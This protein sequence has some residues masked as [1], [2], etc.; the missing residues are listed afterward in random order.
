MRGPRR[1]LVLSTAALAVAGTLAAQP[2]SAS[3]DPGEDR[4][5]RASTGASGDLTPVGP[6]LRDG[7]LA[8]DRGSL[9]AAK[10]RLAARSDAPGAEPVAS[11][12][13]DVKT[14]PALDFTTSD[15][16]VKDY[17]LRGIGDHIQVWVAEDREF[18]DGDCRNALGLTEIT[19]AQVT[20]FVTEFDT[21]I[22]PEESAAFSVPPE[23]TGSSAGL[24]EQLDLPADY[25][26]VPAVESDDTVVLVD[27]VRDDNFHEPTSTDGQTFTAGFFSPDFNQ[28]VDRNVMTI[29]AFDWLHRTGA[30]PPDDRSDPEYAACA[31]ANDVADDRAYGTPRP[32]SY[33][34]TFAHEYQHLLESYAD[35]DEVTWVDEGLADYAQTL[36][37]YVDPSLAADDPA[38]DSHIASFLG[39]GG[40]HFGGPENSLTLWG[41]QGA[42]EILADY[43]AA[44]TMMEYLRDKYGADILTDLHRAPGNGLT[45]LDDVL[46]ARGA[47]RSARRTLHDWA[48]AM[49]LDTATSSDPRWAPDGPLSVETLRATV[50][51]RSKQA[52][53]SPG[54]PPNGSDYV[55]FRDEDGRYLRAKAL[56]SLSFRGARTLAPTPV[57]WSSVAA[58][59]DATTPDSTCDA[60]PAETG[61]QALYSGC[62]RNLDRSIARAV[63]VPDGAARLTFDALWDAEAGWDF[64]FVQVS[65]DGGSSWTSLG[66]T[67]TT[68]EHDPDAVPE[69]VDKLPGFTGDSGSWKSQAVDLSAYAGQQVLLGFRY[70]TD[71]NVDEAGIWLRNIA[72]GGVAV[73]TDPAG[74]QSYTQVKPVAVSGFT[75]RLVGLSASGVRAHSRTLRLDRGF[76][77]ALRRQALR[78]AVGKRSRLVGAIVTYDE[79]T[80]TLTPY[81]R[82]RLTVN[83]HPQPGG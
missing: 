35:P 69:V 31:A 4:P 60:V 5:P 82:Y 83:G 52:F 79:P 9:A 30:T 22:H 37:G 48:A 1:S 45:G 17:T 38:A 42:P 18:P 12:V 71:P 66:A 80:E 29:D 64:A 7:K 47:T 78:Q 59:P 6:D 65:T 70:V 20:G 67:D 51:W 43:G 50:N 39:F 21:N 53:G 36:V 19:D 25:Y 68:T 28:L 16:Y 15:A 13:G 3:A 44:Y 2:G 77:V 57:E 49:A 55:R 62:G 63:S 23:R 14:W 81:A 72:V 54:A 33:E 74:W 32:R 27:N 24:P 61:G 26:Q 34:G 75:V 73:P 40:A 56:R 11:A 41:D 10:R 76:R 58:P 8:L 46:A